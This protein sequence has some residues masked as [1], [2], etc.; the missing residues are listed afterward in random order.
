[1]IRAVGGNANVASNCPQNLISEGKRP[2]WSFS[3]NHRSLLT[4]PS[5]GVGIDLSLQ[6]DV[7]LLWL[8]L[9]VV[10]QPETLNSHSLFGGFPACHNGGAVKWLKLKN[11]G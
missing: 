5:N 1:M 11:G 2:V 9:L 6:L 7:G 8:A 4:K 3:A 10:T